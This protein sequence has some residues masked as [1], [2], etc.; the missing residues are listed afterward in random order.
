[1][2]DFAQIIWQTYTFLVA[3][4]A[5]R[6]YNWQ[7]EALH[8]T[9]SS[10]WTFSAVGLAKVHIEGSSRAYCRQSISSHRTVMSRRAWNSSMARC[11]AKMTGRAGTMTGHFFRAFSAH[12]SKR[13]CRRGACIAMSYYHSTSSA[14]PAICTR[15]TQMSQISQISVSKW[16]MSLRA[17]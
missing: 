4:K 6:A 8:R 13:A 3:S 7:E 14:R 17:R 10:N 9:R 15:C 1:M 5:W 16:F 11:W 2:A 12:H